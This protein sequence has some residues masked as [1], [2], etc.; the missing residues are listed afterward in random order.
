[1][2]GASTHGAGAALWATAEVASAVSAT[3]AKSV[4]VEN[5]VIVHSPATDPKIG[6]TDRG[7]QCFEQ[8]TNAILPSIRRAPVRDFVISRFKL[9][10]YLRGFSLRSVF[11][12]AALGMIDEPRIE[13]LLLCR[14]AGFD[15]GA[16]RPCRR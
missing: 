5:L 2:S 9:R 4:F 16:G 14:I 8:T 6:V 10:G 1:M 11:T 13:G 3:A 7:S 12:N 15:A